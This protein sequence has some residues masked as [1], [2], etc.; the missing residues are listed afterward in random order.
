[1]AIFLASFATIIVGF[2]GEVMEELAKA[3]VPWTEILAVQAIC[4]R[5]PLYQGRVSTWLEFY[6]WLVL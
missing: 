3:G 1:L 6:T 4:E 5:T 2:A